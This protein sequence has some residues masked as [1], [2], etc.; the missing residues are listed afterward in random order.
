[1][2]TVVEQVDEKPEVE[3]NNQG[4]NGQAEES[5]QVEEKAAEE[6]ASEEQEPETIPIPDDLRDDLRQAGKECSAAE[7]EVRRCK[8]ELKEANAAYDTS[9]LTLRGLVDE[10]DGDAERPLLATCG[11]MGDKPAVDPDAW[12]SVDTAELRLP[13]HLAGK[14]PETLG[15][16]EDLRADITQG[17]EKWPK[18]IGPAKITQIED[19]V[20]EWLKVDHQKL[21]AGDDTPDEPVEEPEAWEGV[22]ILELSLSPSSVKAINGAFVKRAGQLADLISD[23]A[24]GHAQWPDGIDATEAANIV[25]ATTKWIF[26]REREEAE[27][28]DKKEA[29]TP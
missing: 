9:V 19:A 17:K 7:A 15:L 5:G 22:D 12:R 25:G 1:M 24:L 26:D 18:G 11:M 27:A 16:L 6:E 29:E 13:A 8:A 14:L 21:T 28:L 2:S 3:S 23:I 4:D 20:V 10:L